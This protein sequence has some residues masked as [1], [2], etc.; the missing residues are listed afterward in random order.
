MNKIIFI[1]LSL[2]IPIAC[3]ISKESPEAGII[4]T[5]DAVYRYDLTNPNDQKK[6]GISFMNNFNQAKPIDVI[7]VDQ[8]SEENAYRIADYYVEEQL[9]TRGTIAGYKIGTFAKGK[10][11]NGPVDGLS[12]PITAVMFSN[13]IHQSGSHISVD[14]CNMSFV[15]ADFGAVVKS[16]AINNAK[17]DL[18]ILAALSGFIPFIEMPDIIQPV[19]GGSNV[20]SIATNYDFKNAFIGGLITTEPTLEWIN[21]LNNFTFT[22]TNETG[23]LLAEGKVENAYEPLYR[24]R[25][26]RDRLLLRGRPLKAGDILSLGNM[27]AIRPLKENLYFDASVRPVFKGNIA[28]VSYIGL[29]PK[30]PATVSVIIDR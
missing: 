25:H 8:L 21:R 12:G 27:G 2:T 13:G 20:S 22:M 30:G 4:F 15:E 7:P 23:K 1:V 24:V 6:L 28:T 18:E 3:E 9:K 11:D 14:C 17:S 5:G 16:S 10:Y 29:D 19:A 26:I